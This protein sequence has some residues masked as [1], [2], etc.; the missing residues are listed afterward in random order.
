MRLED[1]VAP[2]SF[3]YGPRAPYALGKCS[4]S[5]MTCAANDII[6]VI[7]DVGRGRQ[8]SA[9]TLV[10]LND[11]HGIPNTWRSATGRQTSDKYITEDGLPF[12]RPKI[13]SAA[14]FPLDEGTVR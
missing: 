11:R 13:M 10:L 3:I 12:G 2:P 8:S 6:T 9:V 4:S 1:S 7:C 14:P 5:M